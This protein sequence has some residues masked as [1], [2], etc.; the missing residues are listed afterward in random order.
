MRVF[1]ERA[2]GRV[3]YEFR[4]DFST[5]RTHVSHSD[6]ERGSERGNNNSNNSK[7]S[8]E[9]KKNLNFDLN[10]FSTRRVYLVFSFISFY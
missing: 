1:G 8:Y 4:A 10:D 7:C 6:E 2:G 3:K 5:P 9:I